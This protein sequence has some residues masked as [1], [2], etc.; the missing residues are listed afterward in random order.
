M[1]TTMPIL[2]QSV[3]RDERELEKQ[4]GLKTIPMSMLNEEWAQNNHSQTLEGLASRGGLSPDE[5]LANI[6]RRKWHSLGLRCALEYLHVL[7]NN[8][9]SEQDNK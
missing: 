9:L 7:V 8:Y 3:T 2:Y 1:P 6:E 5:L 4:S